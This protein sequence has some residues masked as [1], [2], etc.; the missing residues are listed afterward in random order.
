MVSAACGCLI[1]NMITSEGQAHRGGDGEVEAWKQWS[2]GPQ[3]E[4]H[5]PFDTNWLD[6]GNCPIADSVSIPS[7]NIINKVV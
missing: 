7:F 5:I 2:A 3:R 1:R 6:D 4:D